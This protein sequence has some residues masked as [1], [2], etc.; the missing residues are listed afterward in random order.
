ML[1]DDQIN[2][3]YI[4]ESPFQE[5]DNRFTCQKAYCILDITNVNDNILNGNYI[6][7]CIFI[8]FEINLI[9]SRNGLVLQ[10]IFPGYSCQ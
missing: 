2:R 3:G 8:M 5:I 10:I 9:E 7:F 1:K 4:R 6:H